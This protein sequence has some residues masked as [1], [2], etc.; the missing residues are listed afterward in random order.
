M[1]RNNQNKATQD[2]LSNSNKSDKHDSYEN[3]KPDNTIANNVS[4]GD[5]DGE[6]EIFAFKK[7]T[8]DNSIGRREFIKNSILAGAT[9]SLGASFLTGCETEIACVVETIEKNESIFS[10]KMGQQD[11][12]YSVCISPN[13][14]IL[15]SGSDDKTIKLW[16]IPDGFLLKTLE[17][18]T[19]WIHSV[20]MSP[21]GK[22]LAS[23]G[24]DNIIRLWS[25]PDGVL[26]K[27]IEGHNQS[28]YSIAFSLDGKMLASGSDDKAI[29]LWSIPDG[30]LLKT[31]AGHNQS[32]SSVAF[33]PDGK[34]LASGSYDKTIKLWSIPNGDLLKTLEGHNQSVYSVAF[35]PDGMMLASGSYY[36]KMNNSSGSYKINDN[37]IILW[38]IPSGNKIPITEQIC[39]CDKVCTCNQ[40]ST[41]CE[42]VCTCN[43][44]VVI[45][46]LPDLCSYNTIFPCPLD[47]GCLCDKY[48][49]TYYYTYWYP[50]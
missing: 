11:S 2:E 38:S 28:V 3:L 40:V 1:K 44:V 12:I 31:L 21:E 6:P 5:S 39:V 37:S 16:S 17:G 32:V 15:A 18:H 10:Y 48:I 41:N 47:G 35:N 14:K 45:P 4:S 50:N 27:T 8:E 20:C 33:S 25:I 9:I 34:I 13:G 42:G 36:Q 22:M 26:L 7:N 46:V 43:S 19:S 49:S 23:G 29:K 24:Y 30:V